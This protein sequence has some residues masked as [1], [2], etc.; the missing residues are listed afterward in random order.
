M[1]RFTLK[2]SLL[3]AVVA[4]GVPTFA[5]VSERMAQRADT[6]AGISA[7]TQRTGSEAV[8]VA[9]KNKFREVPA[10]NSRAPRKATAMQAGD[11]P[12]IY[13]TVTQ[14]SYGSA[15]Y[16]APG[17]YELPTADGTDFELVA[18]DINAKYGATLV[19]NYLYVP[20]QEEVDFFGIF[21]S[22]S[23]YDVTD[24][25]AYSSGGSV[26][27]DHFKTRCSAP[28][29]TEPGVAYGC[30]YN[31]DRGYNFSK[32]DYAAKSET[33]IKA[34]STQWQVC[35]I[36][37]SG[38]LYA[39]DSSK[40]LY[41]VDKTTGE[42]TLVATLEGITLSGMNSGVFDLEVGP[43]VSVDVVELERRQGRSLRPG[44]GLRRAY[45]DT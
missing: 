42:Q 43:D 6:P 21:Y 33:A 26:S 34:I 27:N 18:G 12:V 39:I 24:G 19:G 37:A 5:E 29:P 36:N 38:E 30:C 35:G 9:G 25:F 13:G 41:Q 44:R 17:V 14:S 16:N 32:I 31:G 15:T 3:T 7:A 45:A 23:K 20:E 28:D 8:A 1:K 11:V 4:A 2:M 10:A 22:I 40:K